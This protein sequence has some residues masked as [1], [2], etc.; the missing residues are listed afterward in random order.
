[1][2][3]AGC[4]LQSARWFALPKNKKSKLFVRQCYEKLLE[5]VKVAWSSENGYHV[6][7]LGTPGTSKS[8]FVNYVAYKLLS[9]PRQF[10]V[11]ICHDTWI[12]SVNPADN[13]RIGKSL[14]DFEDLLEI[15]DSVVLY[16]CSKTNSQPPFMASCKVLAASSHNPGQYKDFRKFFCTTFCMPLWSLD[17]LELCRQKCFDSEQIGSQVNK[18]PP[19]EDIDGPLYHVSATQLESRYNL[20]G[21]VIRWTIGA[22]CQ[23]A[24]TD[25]EAALAGM[26]LN[27]VL[28]VVGSWNQMNFK[29]AEITHSLIHSDT[30]DMATFKLKFCSQAAC[31]S[32]IQKLAADAENE[33]KKFLTTTSGQS[34]YASLRGQVFEAYAHRIL[35]NKE[36]IPLRF[37][38]G[39][40]TER[41]EIKI[42]KR[43]LKVFENLKDVGD[44]DYCVPKIRNFAAV[45]SLA[46]PCLAFSMTVSLDHPTVASGLL[47]I[48]DAIQK[49]NVLVFVVPKEIETAF[50]KQ[51]YLT[52]DKKI[53]QKL[54]IQ[55]KNIRQ[56]VMA[57][58][59]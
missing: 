25:F 38:D 56:A 21:G 31:E 24:E 28:R 16:D 26:D 7:L 47:K 17:E 32:T 51:N 40:G 9:E 30:Q 1:M 14:H 49:G 42:G 8:F 50:K 23:A 5:K 58:E 22:Q 39:E 15:S 54:P 41:G 53:M 55:I 44:S 33:C 48:L 19:A 43:S 11:I 45:D 35:E 59:F 13:L 36:N 12:V 20:W 46:P 27:T 37:L 57:I 3:E 6:L 10:H 29:G 2:V 18:A 52:V 34:I 4:V